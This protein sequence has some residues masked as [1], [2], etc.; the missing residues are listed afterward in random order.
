MQDLQDMYLINL[1][2]LI[3]LIHR[4]HLINLTIKPMRSIFISTLFL[5]FSISF[6]FGQTKTLSL[7]LP[8]VVT[9]A[10]SDAPD[11]LIANT[12]LNN[13]YWRYQSFLADYKPQI[14]LD[15]TVPNLNRS[16]SSITLP[17][18]TDAFINRSLMSS[19]L[20]LRLSQQITKTG[21]T[22]FASTGLERIDLFATDNIDARTSYLSAPISVGFIQPLFAYNELKW[23]KKIEPLRYSE[24]T[25][26]FAEEMEMVAFEAASLFFDVLIAQ[27]N[28]EAAKQDKVNADTLFA[29]SKGRFRVGKIAETELLQIELQSLNADANVAQTGLNVQTNTE[30]L[31]NHLGI[32][33]AV[34]FELETPAVIPTFSVEA[35]KAL[36]FARMNR[37]NSVNFERR[38]MQ[39]QGEVEQADKD[40]FNIS[41]FGR[42]GLTQ[43]SDSFGDA[44]SDLLDQE[45]VNLGINMP[46]ADWG[47]TKANREIAASNL[48]L[49]K[50]SIEQERIN[51]ERDIL[52]RV[53]QFDLVRN[54]VKLAE[55]AYQ[56]S[57]KRE[58][59][60]RKRYLIAKIGITE[61][62]IAI[63]EKEQARRNYVRALQ[64]FWIAYYELRTLTLYDFAA[65]Q[66]LVKVPEGF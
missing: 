42:F 38:M 23:N 11:V 29:I 47:K 36:K 66:S 35:E 18:G 30:K 22:V 9:L 19:S 45:V 51:F 50:V 26:E 15:A 7:S 12:R 62:N 31:R 59:I 64:T 5:S 16:I 8:E 6:L 44:F 57:I 24:R 37:S 3:Y 17:N 39:A 28:L 56:A 10:Q 13:S 49:T 1:I 53:Q 25:K 43:T 54:Q 41:L 65:D 61:L 46:I 27:L 2:Y 20:D 14:T 34:I 58:D 55:R 4:I 21:G 33:E 60:T 63:S 32:K 48:E 40:R 52:I